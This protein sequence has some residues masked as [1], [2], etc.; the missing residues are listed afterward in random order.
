MYVHATIKQDRRI[1][2]TT[3]GEIIGRLDAPVL[4]PVAEIMEAQNH[5]LAIVA[6][7]AEVERRHSEIA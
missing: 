5:R 1:E 3:D 2:V 4:P 6:R 7:L